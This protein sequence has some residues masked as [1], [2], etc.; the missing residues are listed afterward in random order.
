MHQLVVFLTDD[1]KASVRVELSNVS[2]TEPTLAILVDKKVL[3]V[4]GLI[5]IVPHCYIG[6]TNYNFPSWVGLVCAEVTT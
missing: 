4:L 6:P 3:L 1:L 5:L 2:C